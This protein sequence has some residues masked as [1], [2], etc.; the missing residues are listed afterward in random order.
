MA[1]PKGKKRGARAPAAGRRAGTPN[2]RTVEIETYAKTIVENDKVRQMML[3]QAQN[4][5]LPPGV[6]QMLFYY[7]YGKPKETVDVT[8]EQTL[9]T[10]ELE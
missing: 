7:A 3:L 8:L 10:V 9:Y 5:S 4:G 1:W 2:K 6:V